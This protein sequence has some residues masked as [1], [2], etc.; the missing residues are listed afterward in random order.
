MSYRAIEGCADTMLDVSVGQRTLSIMRHIV[1]RPRG[2]NLRALIQMLA[3]PT[4]SKIDKA[5]HD[6]KP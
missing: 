6:D 5:H 2:R 4:L 1:A 3:T